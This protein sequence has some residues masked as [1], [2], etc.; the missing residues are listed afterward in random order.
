MARETCSA[1]LSSADVSHHL[2]EC[3]H[4]SCPTREI[5]SSLEESIGRQRQCRSYS[6]EVSYA[7]REHCTVGRVSRREGS[8]LRRIERA[9]TVPV[10]ENDRYLREEFDESTECDR[11]VAQRCQRREYCRRSVRSGPVTNDRCMPIDFD[12]TPLLRST[13]RQNHRGS[14]RGDRSDELTFVMK[15][16]EMPSNASSWVRF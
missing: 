4:S 15:S 2:Q 7:S 12:R 1:R 10:M 6:D 14:E 9:R 8:N 5:D 16:F 3:S 13:D 11:V